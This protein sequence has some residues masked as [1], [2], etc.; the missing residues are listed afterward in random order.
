MQSH[1]GKKGDHTQ[2]L[3]YDDVNELFWNPRCLDLQLP[4]QPEAVRARVAKTFM[5]RRSWIQP[6]RAF[7]KVSETGGY[8]DGM[9]RYTKSSSLV[10]VT[11]R[12]TILPEIKVLCIRPATNRGGDVSLMCYDGLG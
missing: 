3:N 11:L 7:E 4:L 12:L 10:A 5:E 9:V 6:I 2:T 1:G 8:L